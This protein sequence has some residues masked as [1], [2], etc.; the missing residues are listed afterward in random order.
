MLAADCIFCKIIKKEIPS[1][2]INENDHVLVIE[3]INPK[4]PFHY[5]IIPKK[6]IIN[7]NHLSDQDSE[8]SA[9]ILNIARDVAKNIQEE[10][11]K[12]TPLPFNL[13]ANN[14]ANASQSVFHMHFHFISGKNLYLN[15]FEL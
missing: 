5:L 10:S 7:I 3:D 2:I 4:A 15:G 1:K 8:Y 9:A 11:G 13:L 14:E 6:H 12:K